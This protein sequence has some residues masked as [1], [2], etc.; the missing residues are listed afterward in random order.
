MALSTTEQSYAVPAALCAS[1][2]GWKQ[3]FC[4]RSLWF[5]S[6]KLRQFALQVAGGL[7]SRCKLVGF[8][9]GNSGGFL[10]PLDD[11]INWAT[12]TWFLTAK[13]NPLWEVIVEKNPNRGIKPGTFMDP[14]PYW[15]CAP[16]DTEKLE[17]LTRK[18]GISTLEGWVRLR[19]NTLKSL[20]FGLMTFSLQIGWVKYWLQSL[21]HFLNM[22]PMKKYVFF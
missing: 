13:T 3:F 20:E 5:P 4:G 22:S 16:R 2:A 17:K 9:E 6:L 8:G 14:K 18:R 15:G 21:G 12:K 10:C 19:L 7:F 1:F 11:C